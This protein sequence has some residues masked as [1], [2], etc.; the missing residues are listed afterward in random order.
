MK[1][2]PWDQYVH[3]GYEID[4]REMN[5]SQLKAMEMWVD[6][7]GDPSGGWAEPSEIIKYLYS[8]PVRET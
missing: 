6:H 5:L 8:L 2:I 1:E 3:I 4:R 7:Y